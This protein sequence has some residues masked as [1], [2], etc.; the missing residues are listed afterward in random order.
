M[1]TW[2]AE[3]SQIHS[4]LRRE[5]GVKLEWKIRSRWKHWMHWVVPLSRHTGVLE[6]T[7]QTIHRIRCLQLRNAKVT[8]TSI[9][10]GNYDNP[11]LPDS[12][13]QLLFNKAVSRHVSNLGRSGHR[14]GLQIAKG[15]KKDADAKRSN[16]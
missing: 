3:T 10:R 6:E 7:I 15:E 14:T 13:W 1:A 2:T 16:S 12:G 11:I 4:S 8:W 5:P 9:A